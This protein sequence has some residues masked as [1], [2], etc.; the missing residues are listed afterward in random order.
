MEK[1]SERGATIVFSREE[2]KLR[3]SPPPLV[4]IESSRR[5]S[6]VGL[7]RLV[8]GSQIFSSP[9]SR[10]SGTPPMAVIGESV[11]ETQGRY[12]QMNASCWRFGDNFFY[13][14]DCL[15]HVH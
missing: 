8:Y 3:R 11:A 5:D 12:G 2:T 14:V 7:Q 4:S 13:S 6:L 9:S 10:H 15:M 1:S